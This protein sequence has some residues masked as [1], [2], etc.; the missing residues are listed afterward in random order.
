MSA[1]TGDSKT[2]VGSES[3]RVTVGGC[4]AAVC[5]ASAQGRICSDWVSDE[6][7]APMGGTGDRR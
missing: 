1:S 7:G 3:Q 5:V 6:G 4:H 2:C